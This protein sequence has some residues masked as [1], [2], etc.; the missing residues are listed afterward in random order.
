MR[1]SAKTS[2]RPRCAARFR[3]RHLPLRSAGDRY[4]RWKNGVA[5]VPDASCDRARSCPSRQLPRMAEMVWNAGVPNPRGCCRLCA[6]CGPS[7][8]HPERGGSLL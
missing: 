3:T 1:D 7:H 6:V 2:R 4:T 5:V 8:P